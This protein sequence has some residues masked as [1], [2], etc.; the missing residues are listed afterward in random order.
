M[1]T[2]GLRTQPTSAQSAGGDQSWLPRATLVWHPYLLLGHNGANVAFCVSVK[3]LLEAKEKQAVLWLGGVC[4]AVSRD[5]R[6]CSPPTARRR[7]SI[8]LGCCGWVDGE[9]SSQATTT[10]NPADESRGRAHMAC[11]ASEP[12]TSGNWQLNLEWRGNGQTSQRPR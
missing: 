7:R 8:L 10:N 12:I 1:P 3:R 5:I 11:A 4:L 2:H 9:Q 6:A